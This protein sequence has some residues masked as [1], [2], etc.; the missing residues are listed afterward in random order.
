MTKL[1]LGTVQFGL[2]YGAVSRSPPMDLKTVLK[3]LEVA[4]IGGVSMLDTAPSYGI[5]EHL[6]GQA[7]AEDFDV[8]TKV[9]DLLF[10]DDDDCCALKVRKQLQGSL[11]RLKRS[12]IYGLLVHSTNELNGENGEKIWAELESMKSEGLVKRI[13]ASIYQAEDL[14]EMALRTIDIVQLPVNVLD[15]RLSRS[16]VLSE[17][18]SKGIEIHARSIFLQ[19]LLIADKGK[20]P[21][22]FEPWRQRLE[23]FWLWCN[24]QQVS[25]MQACIHHVLNME[26]IDKVI[27]GVDSTEQL[28]ELLAASKRYI[29][30][31]PM[32]LQLEDPALL[33]P[34]RWV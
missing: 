34:R 6:I 27:V 20:V 17:L 30:S 1:A 22:I 2:Q 10:A 13:G 32:E 18:K 7:K 23:A 19:G 11:D 12:S 21:N 15:A 14:N 4:R 26:E 29:N 31:F 3:I 9:S 33:D 24:E 8:V 5:S 25:P 28:I 16:G